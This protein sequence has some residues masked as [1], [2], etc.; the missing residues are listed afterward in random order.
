MLYAWWF[1]CFVCLAYALLCLLVSGF[2]SVAVAVL[3]WLCSWLE[4]GCF[5]VC[6]LLAC[7]RVGLGLV[8]LCFDCF[9][10]IF[11]FVSSF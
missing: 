4:C 7:L 1:C 11:I 5:G 8:W 10:L 6:G 2:R 3:P 9:P